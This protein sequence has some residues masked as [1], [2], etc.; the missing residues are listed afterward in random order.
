MV[1][2]CRVAYE[3]G[4]MYGAFSY[5]GREALREA[6]RVRETS[7]ASRCPFKPTEEW[8]RITII[9]LWIEGES[10]SSIARRI[11]VSPSTVNRWIRR[12]K[13]EGHVF[14]RCSSDGVEAV[15]V[16]E[17]QRC[18]LSLLLDATNMIHTQVKM[19][20]EKR[21]PRGA[22]V[23][24]AAVRGGDGNVTEE[25]LSRSVD[26]VQWLGGA[27]QCLVVVVVSDDP[28]FLAAFA[29]L[30]LRRH[31]LRWSTRILFLT[32]L[33]LSHLGGLHGLLSTR[34][35]MLLLITGVKEVMR[36]NV[37]MLVPYVAPHTRPVRVAS[38]DTREGLALLS[39]LPL[40][41]DKYRKFSH[42]PE[43]LLAIQVIPYHTMRWEDDPSVPEGRRLIVE[44]A[45]DN[46][47]RYFSKA[48]NFTVLT[49]MRATYSSRIRYMLASGRTFGTKLPDGTWTGMMGLVARE[50]STAPGFIE[51][52]E[53][54][55]D[56]NRCVGLPSASHALVQKAAP[57][58]VCGA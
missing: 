18:T 22:V 23:L 15:L 1:H 39:R 28:A 14:S 45:L 21:A 40:F 5:P 43:L 33:S 57:A 42:G 55:R 37:Y 47:A 10:S 26:H 32:R 4:I 9:M 54:I 7:V 2:R 30:S 49:V 29:H 6:V 17:L 58:R 27:W 35:A 16:Q 53:A 12:W 44:G 56:K 48:L 46:V 36:G 52:T 38:W 41:P 19:L 50:V 31:A 3:P 20:L 51:S 8:E 11:G 25:G 34:N 24:E 13:Q